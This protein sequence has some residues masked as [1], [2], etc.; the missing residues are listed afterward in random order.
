M[1]SDFYSLKGVLEALLKQNQLLLAIEL[2]ED[3]RE[4]K[5]EIHEMFVS[6]RNNDCEIASNGRKFNSMDDIKKVL[7][8]VDAL[9]DLPE[10]AA[11]ED[12]KNYILEQM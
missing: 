10:N 2:G 6:V 7:D 12:V 9:R 1:V 4:N 11:A 3:Y 8:I 5:D